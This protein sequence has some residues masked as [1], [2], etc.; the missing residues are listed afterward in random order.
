MEQSKLFQVP[1]AIHFGCH[2]ADQAG[3]EA[4]RL[5]AA[6][7]LIVTDENLI[8]LGVVAPV[9]ASLKQA[10]IPAVIY[11][12]VN[13]EPTLEHVAGGLQVLREEGCDLVIA[14]G[15][16]S[17]IDAAKAIAVM[18]VNQGKL[19]D[20]LGL[21]K[22]PKA[23]LPLIAVPTTAGTG[24]EATIFTII[25]D[26][27]RNVKMPIGSPYLIARVALVD[28]LLTL[29]LPPLLTAATGLDA[30]TH[31]IEAYVSRKAQPLSDLLAL[32]ALELITQNIYQAWA[33][34]QNIEART[35]VMLG[36]LQ[37]GMAFSNS[38]I[39][40][41]HG[42][43]RP[44]GA[45]FHLPHGLT[46]TAI[47][48]VVTEYSIAGNQERYARIAAALGADT[49]G[50]SSIE[51]AHAGLAVIKGL[52]KELQIPSLKELVRDKG[53]FEERL[54]QMAKDAIASGSPA[55]NPRTA[56]VEDI[57]ALYRAAW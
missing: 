29:T 51:A 34:P 11:D 16:G 43:S 10:G 9:Q 15:G 5:S 3:P 46:N 37:A 7:A 38:S 21:G 52:L 53:K 57:V 30:L 27:D 18:A 8:N 45:N 55:H 41:V 23:G 28:P 22:I 33:N 32:S 1:P 39:A 31:G 6:K 44:I 48:S 35:K 47:L 25:T 42:M 14:V 50:L 17:P 20:Y 24:S 2:A 54:E 13:V 12:G 49:R 26:Q 56:S 36:A 40:L 19:Q 4:A